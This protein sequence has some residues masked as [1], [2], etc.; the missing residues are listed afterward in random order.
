MMKP[1]RSKLK[2]ISKI[3]SK[4]SLNKEKTLLARRKKLKQSTSPQLTNLL[5]KERET[6]MLERN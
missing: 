4:I 5:L 2:L 3:S 1:M 6:K